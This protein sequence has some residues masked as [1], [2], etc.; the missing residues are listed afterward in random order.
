MAGLSKRSF[1][2]HPKA[3]V[4][5]TEA[6]SECVHVLPRPGLLKGVRIFEKDRDIF[7]IWSMR[8]QNVLRNF[9]KYI[10]DKTQSERKQL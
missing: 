10:K 6:P 7:I 3:V 4:I 9:E 5:C 1:L 2:R 8:V